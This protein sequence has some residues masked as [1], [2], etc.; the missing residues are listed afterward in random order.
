MWVAELALAGVC[1][2][3]GVV[4]LLVAQSIVRISPWAVAR[5]AI[6]MQTSRF[7]F[8]TLAAGALTERKRAAEQ[9]KVLALS[10]IVMA[11]F[12]FVMVALPLTLA[13]AL[14]LALS[15]SLT[16][17]LTL[18][19]SLTLT[20]TLSLTLHLLGKERRLGAAHAGVHL[21]TARVRVSPPG[22]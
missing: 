20:L 1:L 11:V 2:I 10:K 5:L 6:G 17:T 4:L 19:L 3:Y 9:R 7:R 15:L 21:E 18:S 8:A 12:F 16:L 13:L 14:T 22:G